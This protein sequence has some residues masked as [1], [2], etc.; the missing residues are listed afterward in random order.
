M[1]RAILLCIAIGVLSLP[2]HGCRAPL[3]KS[4]AKQAE[5]VVAS[6]QADPIKMY[7]AAGLGLLVVG[8]IV[9]AFGGK[10]T[11]GT[12][13]ALGAG[14]AWFG[15]VLLLHSWLSIVVIIGIGV[16]VTILAYDRWRTNGALKESVAAIQSHGDI[17]RDMCNGDAKKQ[18]AIRPVIDRVKRALRAEGR[19][20]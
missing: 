1:K 9:I 6:I 16:I 11:G 3:L 10:A 19:L 12:L 17:K 18:E 15:Q 8:A 4:S 7:Y 20:L 5:S 13:C 2:F 14:I